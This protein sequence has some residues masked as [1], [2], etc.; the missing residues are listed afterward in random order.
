MPELKFSSHNYGI[1]RETMNK[2]TNVHTVALNGLGKGDSRCSRTIYRYAYNQRKAIVIDL[3][4]CA[5]GN[6]TCIHAISFI[7]L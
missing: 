7:P 6:T 3:I 4:N 1:T 2:N 5:D